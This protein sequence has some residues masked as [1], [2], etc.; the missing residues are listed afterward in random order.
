M[1]ETG[2]V[3]HF[4]VPKTADESLSVMLEEGESFYPLRHYHPE[5]QMT[6]ILSGRGTRFIGDSIDSFLE[7]E[8]YIIGSNVPHVFKSD[9][10]GETAD[11]RKTARSISIYF[12]PEV[13][14]P[15]YFEMPETRLIREMIDVTSRGI[16]LGSGAERMGHGFME[17][18]EELSGFRRLQEFLGFM[19]D[20][21]ESGAYQVL[22]GS[23][24]PV[25]VRDTDNRR[26]S[27][28]F[29]FVLSNYADDISLDRVASVASMSTTAFCR[30]FRMH[31]R[32]TF[33]E[34]LNRTRTGKAS[35]LVMETDLPVSEI[36]YLSGYNSIPYFIRQYRKYTGI[37]PLAHRR[38]YRRM[39]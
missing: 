5:M 13:L 27:D 10:A 39:A 36:A 9:P 12:N 20:L 24:Y 2:T 18:M 23:G 26:L 34:F 6:L 11:V 7:N 14:G 15:G 30:Y 3:L 38:K 28:V 32:Q 8:C 25:P 16:K 35:R 19:N 33:T 31:T 29:E 37:S 4:R 22:S 1:K 17:R 21:R